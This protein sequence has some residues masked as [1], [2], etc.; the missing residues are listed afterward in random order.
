[1]NDRIKYA[2]DFFETWLN[3]F[4]GLT[5]MQQQNFQIK[6]E[7][8]FR[9]AEIARELAKALKLSEEDIESLYIA[10]ILHDIGRF[11]QLV[12]YNTFNDDK[13]VDHADY[14]VQILKEENIL[15]SLDDSIR[16]LILQSIRLHN[17]FEIPAKLTGRDRLY[18][19][20]LRDADKLD[21][22][23][24]LTDYYT[25]KDREPNHILTWELP[26]G[27]QVSPDIVQDILAEKLVS[28][29]KVRSEID[30]KVL[31]MSWVYDLNFRPSFG[32]LFK[33][34]YLEKIYNTLPKNDL[35]IKIYTK[36]KVFAENRL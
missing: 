13:S 18:I 8:S 19:N 5:D 21:I 32:I 25:D 6:K 23:K 16:E 28:K 35:I 11:R 4:T 36:V 14:S 24:V 27:I 10:G 30:I 9:V 2:F 12:E 34:R 17:K 7:H 31:Q 3:S 1:M 15:S 33:N 29:S 26:K 20:L 22:M